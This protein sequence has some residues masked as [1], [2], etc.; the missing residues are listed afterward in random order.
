VVLAGISAKDSGAA[1]GSLATVQQVGAA[2]GIAVVGV[3]FFGLLGTNASTSSAS[4]VPQLRTELTVAGVPQQQ[5][6]LIVARFD[7]CFAARAHSTDPS[8]TPALCEQT[9]RQLAAS[10]APAS[11][12]SAVAAAIDDHAVPAARLDDFT[13]SMRSTLWWQVAVFALALILAGRLPRVRLDTADTMA[14][15]A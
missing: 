2:L 5:Q 13:Q 15:G 6:P 11:V 14:G 4:A 3:I 12:K 1:S 9:A 8:A 10:P 7:A